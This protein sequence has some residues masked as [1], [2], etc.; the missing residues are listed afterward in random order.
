[1]IKLRLVIIGN[2]AAGLAA[3]G[4][5]HRNLPAA[6]ITI[7]SEEA[8]AS[9]HRCLIADV[10]AGKADF[11]QIVFLPAH[12]LRSREI[13]L[14]HARAVKLLPEQHRVILADGRELPYDQL[15][16]ATGAAPAITDLPGRGLNGIFGFRSYTDAKAIAEA[17]AG[18]TGAVVLGGGL[19]GL[20]A[21]YALKK[22]GL[23]RV[24][25]VV[26]SQHLMVKQLE[27]E[28]AALV[29]K[30]FKEY[31]LELIF[32]NDAV[33]FS[34]A[35]GGKKVASVLLE[36]GKEI[37]AQVVV[38]GKGVRPRAELV[39]QAGGEV[40]R[41]IVVNQL[42]QTSLPD[43]YAAGDCIE[44]ADALTGES[45]PSGLWPLAVEQG[46]CAGLCMTGRP[47]AYPPALTVQNS[48]RFGNLSLIT[49]GRRDGETQI[50]I[51]RREPA[52]GVLKKFFVTGDCLRGYILVNSM[53]GAG[54]YTA[55]VRSGRRVPGL[56]RLLAEE[57]PP[58]Q[59]PG[60]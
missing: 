50:V 6:R 11:A 53:E 43:I 45:A 46:R 48:V 39:K 44:V 1:V 58:L 51:R 3:A 13:E 21:A 56:A 33:A 18:A 36:N 14:I 52:P 27:P 57:L 17:S 34:P 16:V 42:L 5:A 55:L 2:S 19:V 15:L 10:L 37:P 54:I 25:L 59:A 26:K 35:P 49:A 47:A 24:V 60:R 38:S 40:R 22:R 30:H 31:G 9:Y 7:I 4:A 23:P 29:E 28:A 8:E 32:Q 20:K 41:G 12:G